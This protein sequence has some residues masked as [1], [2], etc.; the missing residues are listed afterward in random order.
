MELLGAESRLDLLVEGREQRLDDKRESQMGE[1]M[2]YRTLFL[3]ASDCNC[4]S[5][6]TL[7][8]TRHTGPF[9]C[10]TCQVVK[11]NLTFQAFHLLRDK[12][13]QRM[14][15]KRISLLCGRWIALSPASVSVQLERWR[16]HQR[17][18]FLRR[19]IHLRFE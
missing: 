10:I 15:N 8:R 6:E 16:G 3:L 13:S 12:A 17:E 9:Q 11:K 18:V 1:R 14:L 2:G 5:D 19:R 7:L 4:I